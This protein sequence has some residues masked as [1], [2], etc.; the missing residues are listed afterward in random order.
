MR[1]KLSRRHHIRKRVW[2]S[3]SNNQFNNINNGKLVTLH[4]ADDLVNPRTDIHHKILIH[5]SQEKKEKKR[6]KR[7]DV[8]GVELVLNTLH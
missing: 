3:N 8:T 7:E 2:T 6:K 4:A 5:V 1:M